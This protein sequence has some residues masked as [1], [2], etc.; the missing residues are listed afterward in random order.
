MAGLRED[1]DN[2]QGNRR[3]KKSSLFTFFTG[4]S[5]LA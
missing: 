1:F 5:V 2:R 4:Y 3:E